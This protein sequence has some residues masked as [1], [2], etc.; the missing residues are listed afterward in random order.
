M[1]QID[2]QRSQGKNLVA[3][4]FSNE[5]LV[6]AHQNKA[7]PLTSLD[8]ERIAEQFAHA[9][10]DLRLLHQSS[11]DGDFICALQGLGQAAAE[12]GRP[13][14]ATAGYLSELF[15][16]YSSF[17]APL[18]STAISPVCLQSAA[19]LRCALASL[20]ENAEFHDKLIGIFMEGLLLT[21]GEVSSVQ[22]NKS[23]LGGQVSSVESQR[24]QSVTQHDCGAMVSPVSEDPASRLQPEERS[25]EYAVEPS[26][27]GKWIWRCPKVDMPSPRI[28]DWLN[29]VDGYG[30]GMAV[31]DGGRFLAASVRGRGHKQ[32]ALFCDDT[33]EFTAIGEWR[34]VITSDGAGSAIFS[35]VGS[36]IACTKMRES[37]ERTLGSVDLSDVVFAEQDL[38]ELQTNPSGDPRL[39]SVIRALE[40]GFK[41]SSDAITEWAE[42]KNAEVC[43]IAAE[44]RFLE[45]LRREAMKEGGGGGSSTPNEPPR[46]K[47]SDCNCTLLVAAYTVVRL[48]KR[49]GSERRLAMIVSCAVGD[50]M[51]V[52]LRK[53][54]APEPHAS[55][56]MTPDMGAFAGQ[57]HFINQFPDVTATV[58]ARA[59][60]SFAGADNDVV[61]V[62]AMTDGVAD[63]YYDEA[64]MQRLYCDLII[65][66]LLPM[67]TDSET[68]EKEREWSQAELRRRYDLAQAEIKN[69]GQ[70]KN[71]AAYNT[72]QPVSELS[73][74][75]PDAEMLRDTL[76]ELVVSE[77][78][79][80]PPEK[81]RPPESRPVKYALRYAEALGLTVSELLARPG[82]LQVILEA[83]PSL[84]ETSSAQ[85]D[86]DLSA[87][88][89]SER[90]FIWL[91]TYVVRGSFDDRTVVM[92]HTGGAA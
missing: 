87:L 66:G 19:N 28:G 68:A 42:R 60:V 84:A 32:D 77:Q 72:G 34:V 89:A 74:Q 86:R 45:G 1:L 51:I 16:G 24:D 23:C 88:E 58:R 61:A 73:R 55:M 70:Q 15:G 54:S 49:D 7:V 59:A 21:G 8:S 35:R 9:L 25:S 83:L 44:R 30:R 5:A 31:P 46:I 37:L 29:A 38:K 80:A 85:D 17:G 53:L 33:F 22:Q 92:F 18:V 63:D 69:R 67:S 75:P 81:G 48:I 2:S 36:Q 91:D 64:G 20:L 43:P 50:G 26:P 27:A 57:T 14:E 41:A 65:N 52:V 40:V 71:R 47:T 39:N 78:V 56:L 62:I 11:L 76:S 12:S 90:L 6:E 10:L 4:V 13:I 82:L 3:D 79:F